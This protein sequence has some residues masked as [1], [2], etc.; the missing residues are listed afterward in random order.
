MGRPTLRSVDRP[1]LKPNTASHETVKKQMGIRSKQAE[2]IL[3]VDNGPGFIPTKSFL[4]YELSELLEDCKI[5]FLKPEAYGLQA[6]GVRL[7]TLKHLAEYVP[8]E[9]MRND[10]EE[11][12]VLDEAAIIEQ[13]ILESTPLPQE[14]KR[15]TDEILPPDMLP[16]VQ[17]EEAAPIAY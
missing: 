3:E 6:L 4:L 12:A 8:S 1:I 7:N 17:Q 11:D 10:S 15:S 5:G 13:Y 9:S 14:E 2:E 16:P